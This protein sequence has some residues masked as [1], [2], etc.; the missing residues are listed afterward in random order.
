MACS[1]L[2]SALLTLGRFGFLSLLITAGATAIACSS[3]PGRDGTSDGKNGKNGQGSNNGGPG[4]EPGDGPTP[5]GP[6][7]PGTGPDGTEYCQEVD[8][9]FE[10]R[11]PTVFVLVDRS[12]SMFNGDPASSYWETLK[13][14]VLP[15]IEEL[16]GDVRFGFAAYTGQN[17]STCPD[18]SDLGTLSENNYEAIASYYNGLAAPQ[19]KGETPT[20]YAINEAK[21]ILLADPSPGDRFILLVTDGDPDFCDDV[22]KLCG[23]DAL[24]A[25]LQMAAAEG[26]RTLVFGIDNPDITPEWFDY[27]AQAGWGEEP[28]WPDG[29]EVGEHNGKLN[30]QCQGQAPWAAIHAQ[31]AKPGNNMPAGHY[32]PEGGTAKAFL[33]TDPAALATQIRTAVEGL[34]SCVFDLA[35]SNVEVKEGSESE[36]Q[37]YVNEELIP[38]EQWRMNN[39]TTL[40]LLGEA[41]ETWQ[42][43]DV[44]KFFAG[45]PCEAIIIR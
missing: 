31:H 19:Y 41:C 37:I 5:P 18:L 35:A 6:S 2:G 13:N 30:D 11:T 22:N 21:E 29:L 33:N 16:Q 15:V 25:T 9:V 8:V 40:E 3:E 23:A 4:D 36:G 17:G 20:A 43:P 39:P 12:S 45:F 34:K 27:Y 32:S 1:S 26:V 7:V 24:I 10:P 44:D 38:L 42:R 14:A 28:N